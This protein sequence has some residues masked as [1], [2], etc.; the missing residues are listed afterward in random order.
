MFITI[1]AVLVTS[2]ILRSLWRA[3]NLP[4]GPWGLPYIGSGLKM[5]SDP[6]KNAS[7]AMRGAAKYDLEKIFEQMADKDQIVKRILKRFKFSNRCYYTEKEE[8]NVILEFYDPSLE[9]YPPTN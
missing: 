3:W 6:M 7:N 5:E 2:L 9:D 4:A 8:V 1:L